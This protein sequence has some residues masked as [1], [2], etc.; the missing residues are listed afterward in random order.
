MALGVGALYYLVM[1][2]VLLFF[3]SLPIVVIVLAVRSKRK[4]PPPFS[5]V[6]GAPPPRPGMSAGW[7]VAIV[8]SVSC[9]AVSGVGIL[10]AMLLPALAQVKENANRAK[11]KNNLNQIGKAMILYEDEYGAL[12]PEDG[13][14]MAAVLYNTTLQNEQVFICPSSDETPD[15]MGLRA[16][17]EDATSY[18]FLDNRPGSRW[19]LSGEG[20]FDRARTVLAADKDDYN[21]GDVY[22]L[23]YADGHVEEV[24]AENARSARL[25]EPLTR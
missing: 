1:M 8:L 7:I 11:C 21:H 25:L 14:R 19:R 2:G 4:T 20:S 12:P 23:L 6:E 13:A 22:I 5:T 16:G 24:S 3:V 10:A 9:V 18:A 17:R 15:R